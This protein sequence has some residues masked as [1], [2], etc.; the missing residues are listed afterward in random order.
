MSTK[1]CRVQVV[2]SAPADPAAVATAIDDF[3]RQVMMSLQGM[4]AVC[5]HLYC[6]TATLHQGRL[7]DRGGQ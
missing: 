3:L 5:S 4:C 7:Q 2:E 1:F 6:Q